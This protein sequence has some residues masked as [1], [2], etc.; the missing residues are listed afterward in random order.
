MRITTALSARSL[1]KSF[2]GGHGRRRAQFG[3]VQSR[4]PKEYHTSTPV[5]STG[6]MHFLWDFDGKA[7]GFY[8]LCF[9]N[10]KLNKTN[11]SLRAE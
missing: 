7:L 10:Y 6:R 5:V 4:T 3:D 11:Q 1:T 8:R 2:G 9:E